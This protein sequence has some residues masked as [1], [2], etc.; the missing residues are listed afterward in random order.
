MEKKTKIN[1]SSKRNHKPAHRIKWSLKWV[2]TNRN[3]INFGLRNIH[4]KSF[5]IYLQTKPSIEMCSHGLKAGT[6]SS[7]QTR[8]RYA[9]SFLIPL[10]IK[11]V[12][13]IRKTWLSGKLMQLE[14][15]LIKLLTWN[16]HIITENWLPYMVH[17]ELER[18]QWHV[19]LLNSVV[20]KQ[21]ISMQV[22]KGQ[23]VILSSRWRMHLLR[24]LI[25]RKVVIKSQF[26]WSLMKLMELLQVALVLKKLLSSWETAFKNHHLGTRVKMKRKRI[27]R[28]Q[29]SVPKEML[30]SSKEERDQGEMITFSNFKDQSF[31][32]AMICG[33]KHWDHWKKSLFKSKFLNQIKRDWFKDSD[34]YLNWR[35]YKPMI[36]SFKIWLTSATTIQEHQLTL[37]N[38]WD[39]SLETKG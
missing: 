17:Q 20:M 1:K 2:G 23:P 10:L 34:R 35:T 13:C 11:K 22:I 19:S 5:S 4:L 12:P 29:I 7:F 30:W 3:K 9:W 24:T 21:D 36:W 31:S 6:K 38:S 18:Q 16:F 32:S 14:M 25:S 37:C 39:R 33:Q 27:L 26:V 28:C 15:F 8:A